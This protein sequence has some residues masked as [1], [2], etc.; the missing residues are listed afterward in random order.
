MTGST[1]LHYAAEASN[2]TLIRLLCAFDADA[3]I[4]D[5]SGKTP[6]DIVKQS[7]S[8]AAKECTTALDEIAELQSKARA[9]YEA[10]KSDPLPIVKPGTVF[11]LSLD[12]GGMKSLNTSQIAIA[13]E[14]RMKQLQPNCGS[15]A[16]CFDFIAGT[17]AGGVA[18]LLLG[19]MSAPLTFSR[20]LVMRYFSSIITKPLARWEK[21]TRDF[22]KEVFGSE[23]TLSE[24][25]KPKTMVMC[26][27]ANQSPP[28]LHMMCN[29]G[30]S[31]NGQKA[32]NER[33]LWE[34]A[35][36]TGAAPAHFPAFEGNFLD[37]G[38]MANNPTL[39]AL[40][41][42]FEESKKS[43][44]AM[45]L[46]CVLSIGTGY[47]PP[48]PV[49]KIDFFIPSAT[50]AVTKLRENISSLVNLLNLLVAQVTRSDG[51]EVKKAQTWC[52][53]LGVPYFRFSP[54]LH[55]NIGPTVTDMNVMCKML[56]NTEKY[57]L[58]SSQQIDQ[59]AKLL[60][61]KKSSES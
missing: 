27:L 12:G 52:E 19:H 38:L 33:K 8:K 10:S 22:F 20:A 11:L 18:T 58:E 60:L 55:D 61:A 25:L 50:S 23:S 41:E 17:S 35:C 28:E 47:A 36:A 34:A 59:I 5:K 16:S 14:K 31:R 2:I 1:A 21:L 43:A 40:V 26:T 29:Y 3:S 30:G 46:G 24:V 39:E 7:S 32:P 9:F 42:I 4:P 6:L 37:G 45:E 54:P 57:I 49:D 56:F 51:S 53:L 44:Q 13:I 15:F 48:K